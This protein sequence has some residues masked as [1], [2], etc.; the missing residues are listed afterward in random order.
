MAEQLGIIGLGKIGGNLAKQAIEK[1]IEV[2]GKDPEDKPEL[3]EKGVS[4]VDSYKEFV[5]KL[6]TPRIIYLSLPAGDTID[7][8]IKDL[9]PHL[10][11]DDVLMD[12]GNSF[13][14]DSLRRHEEIADRKYDFI[15]CGTSGGWE[16]ARN[17]ACF[18]V[19]G[20]ED[21]VEKARPILEKLSVE[22]GFVHVGEPG[23]GHFVKLVHNGIEFGML[24][25]IGEGV[26][27]LKDGA[28]GDF[29]LD[30]E[31][32]TDL[33]HNWNN[34]SVIRSWLI[35]LMEEGLRSEENP[36]FEEIPN[37]IEDTGE[38]N[39]LVQEAINSETPVPVISQSIM[40][41]FKS[42]GEQREAYRAIALMRNGFGGHPF[43]EDDYIENER[44][45]SRIR[46]I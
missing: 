4:T 16:G 10:D 5:E 45:T 7:K 25:A 35:Q 22:G 26:E 21:V 41:L 1:D 17:G 8:V 38:V 30:D 2:V 15:D 34:G 42:R 13:Y 12:G 6:E 36:D 20:E 33:F 40:E 9:E 14:R 29:D 31:Q 37:Y 19:G 44:E 23:T 43:G 32:L 3:E 27:L 46:K 39:W 18:M 11:E 24:Q 28:G